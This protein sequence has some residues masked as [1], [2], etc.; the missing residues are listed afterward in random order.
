MQSPVY[1]LAQ[2]ML[3]ALKVW[4]REERTLPW[5]QPLQKVHAMDEQRPHRQVPMQG[6]RLSL[7]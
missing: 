3:T 2:V 4:E 1:Q 6:T 7:P 5:A